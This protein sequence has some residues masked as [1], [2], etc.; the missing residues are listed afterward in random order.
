MPGNILAIVFKGSAASWIRF[1]N[2]LKLR[3]LIR[4]SRVAGKDAYIISEINKAAA[5][6]EGFLTAGLDVSS[7]PG[8][9]ATDGK[10]NPFYDRWGYAA[11]G[12]IRALARYPRPT[13]FLFDVLK[14]SNDTFRLKRLFYA[15]GGEN[16]SNPGVSTKAEVLSN[17]V[18]VP[19]GIASGYLSQ[20]TSYIGPSQIVKGQFNKNMILM[21]AAESFFLLAEAKQRYGAAVTLPLTAQAYYEQGVKESF[22]LTGTAAAAATTL[23]TSGK[24]LADWTAS[25]DKLKAIWMQK[26]IALV[27]YGGLEAWSEFRRTNFP[28]TP[29]SASG[30][31]NQKLPLRLF[32]PQTESTSNGENVTGQGTIDVFNTRI[33]WDVD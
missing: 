24:D 10:T 17:Y 5:T 32:Y 12:T 30:A 20:N 23:L 7:N 6:A 21:T 25:P 8:Y 1:A 14:A 22:R 11:N 26:W 31:A 33:F 28:V 13:V 27:N 18:P 3:I 9:L 29:P 2:S 19:F 15:A 16:G 4:Q